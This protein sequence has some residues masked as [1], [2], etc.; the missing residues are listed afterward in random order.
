MSA[1][2]QW[3]IAGCVALLLAG[4]TFGGTLGRLTT[5]FLG[6]EY[7]DAYGTQWFYWFVD[8]QLRAGETAGHSDLFFH[9]WGKDV[10]A[11]TGTNVLDAYAAFPFRLL[12]GP[13]L[14]YNAFLLATLLVNGIV[15]GWLARQFTS[16]RLAIGV[17]SVLFA[18]SPFVLFEAGAGRPTQALL[19]FPVLVV[20][21]LWRTGTRRGLLSPVLA[22][23]AL[24]LSGYQY[25]YYAFFVGMGCLAH[26]LWRVAYPPRDAGGRWR[27]L[28]RHALIAGV[29]LAVTLPF[30]H[31]LLSGGATGGESVPGLLDMDRWSLRANPP[32]TEAGTK[33]GLFLW[34]PFLRQTGAFVQD[35][36]GTERFL[37]R[38]TWMLIPM[39]LSLALWAWRPGKLERGPVL[40][41]VALSLAL[42]LGPML[43]L[44]GLALPN[45]LY[46]GL[47]KALPFMQRLWW[48]ARAFVVMSIL[49]NLSL[50]VNIA[51]LR[52]RA[53]WLRIGA[54]AG[55]ALAWG[56]ELAALGYL[57]FPTWHAGVPAGYRCLE[58]GPEGALM[59]LPFA[60]TQAHLYYQTQHGRPVMGGM[61]ENNPEFTPEEIFALHQDNT[62]VAS[63]MHTAHGIPGDTAWTEEDRQAVHTL[64]YRYVVL[65]KDAYHVA[66]RDP[67]LLDNVRRLQQRR[68]TQGLQR[69]AGPPVYDDARVA[70]FA[71]WGD[72]SPCAASSPEP[73]RKPLGRTDI[74]S[75]E[76]FSRP[77]EDQVLTRLLVPRP[78]D[79]VLY[80]PEESSLA[81][82]DSAVADPPAS[83]GDDDSAE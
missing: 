52:G 20:L 71:P 33:V 30:A 65:Q 82:D 29:A 19:V 80:D 11:H 12:L 78:E 46:I 53:P 16:D 13:V 31:A 54:V 42:S 74:P 23:L 2:P 26:G 77:F 36:D 68:M 34:Q 43:L 69:V 22:G 58:Q 15:F 47:S 18:F 24:A 41:M 37:F 27:L 7:V 55:L 21:F 14:G 35:L 56:V 28:A 40:A 6:F 45:P 25:W 44:G 3:L 76:L 81:D 9:P 51:H 48:P 79:L 32:I 49:V 64:G 73:D 70:I 72:P 57:P 62:F 8:R 75:E 83:A 59:E 1:R 50:V 38:G 61:L 63:M 4:W 39:W 10:F 5:E 66:Q 17:G 67:G 60:W